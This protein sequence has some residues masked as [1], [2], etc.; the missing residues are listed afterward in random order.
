LQN[1]KH[2]TNQLR[3]EIRRLHSSYASLLKE[4]QYLK[5]HQIKTI[6][7]ISINGFYSAGKIFYFI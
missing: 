7:N 2:K 1:E 6:E 4:S 3:N 5:E